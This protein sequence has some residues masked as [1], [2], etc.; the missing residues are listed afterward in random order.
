VLG[1]GDV[2]ICD[3]RTTRR[4]LQR[5]QMRPK[6]STAIS[7]RRAGDVIVT[8]DQHMCVVVEQRFGERKADARGAAGDDAAFAAKRVFRPS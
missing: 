8:G 4:C 6:R 2:L 5:A 7:I 1:C 3:V